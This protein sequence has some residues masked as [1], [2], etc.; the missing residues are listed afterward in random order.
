MLSL[1][2]GQPS[3]WGPSPEVV[4]AG[5][6]LWERRMG[7]EQGA[8][9]AGQGGSGGD[10]ELPWRPEVWAGKEKGQDILAGKFR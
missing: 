2:A 4:Q 3:R 1:A 5:Y 6:W 9:A 8:S 10:L 7:S